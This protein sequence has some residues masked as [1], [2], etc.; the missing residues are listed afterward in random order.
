MGSVYFLAA[1]AARYRAGEI[2]K[3]EYN[4]W[5]YHYPKSDKGNIWAEVPPDLK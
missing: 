5:H 1:E 3:E 2:S 4:A